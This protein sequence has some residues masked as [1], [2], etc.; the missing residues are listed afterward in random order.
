MAIMHC[1]FDIAGDIVRQGNVLTDEVVSM[2]LLNSIARILFVVEQTTE[3]R[4]AHLTNLR[5]DN[6]VQALILDDD[7]YQCVIAKVELRNLVFPVRISIYGNQQ[8]WI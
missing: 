4:I 8:L 7:E 2:K 1:I 3:A 6:S 5:Q